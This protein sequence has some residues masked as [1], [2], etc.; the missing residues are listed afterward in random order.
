QARTQ[1]FLDVVAPQVP[2]DQLLEARAAFDED[3]APGPLHTAA[4]ALAK[5][6]ETVGG[7]DSAANAVR[8]GIGWID[9]KLKEPEQP[10]GPETKPY[11]R[12][13]MERVQGY[14]KQGMDSAAADAR[15][16]RDIEAGKDD[17]QPV[18]VETGS[19]S[20]LGTEVKRGFMGL[21][22]SLDG[23]MLSDL[24]SAVE[25]IRKKAKEQGVPPEQVT[26]V[27]GLPVD[28]NS[29]VK[30][31]QALRDKMEQRSREMSLLPQSSAVRK[32]FEGE[33]A[34]GVDNFINAFKED[35]GGAV[36]TIVGGSVP[37]SLAI[38]ATAAMTRLGGF[39]MPVTAAAGGAA[40]TSVELGNKYKENRDK[41]MGHKEAWNRA[42]IHSGAIGAF[43]AVSLASAGRALGEL[44]K[45]NAVK[46]WLKE[47]GKQAALGAGGETFG[48]ALSGEMPQPGEVAAE[49]IGEFVLGVPEGIATISR[50]GPKSDEVPPAETDPVPAEDVLGKPEQPRRP[51]KRAEGAVA[52][53]AGVG[54]LFTDPDQPVA[55]AAPGATPAAAAEAPKPPEIARGVRTR[56]ATERGAQ[57]EG[58][59][60]VVDAEAL[61]ASHDTALNVNKAYP[62]ELQPRDRTRDASEV[63][64]ARIAQNLQPEFLGGS[65]QA[66]QGAPII[67]E[68]GVVESGNARSI[69]LKRAYGEGKAESYRDWVLAN[70][71]KFGIDPAELSR[72]KRPVLV[73]VR[74]TPVNRAEFARQANESS[75]AAFSPLEQARA[76]ATRLKSLEDLQVGENGEI[77]TG[78]NMGFIRRFVGLLPVT[79]QAGLVTGTGELSQAGVTRMR[80]AVLA[81]A[82][83]GGDVLMR[84]VE[85]PDDNI[86]NITAGLVRAAPRVAK[87]R[88]EIAAGQLHDL[89]I[90]EDLLKAVEWLSRL[91]AD[92]KSVDQWM[93]QISF[94]EEDASAEFKALMRF[95]DESSRSPR[96]IAE[97]I[98]LYLAS[99]D[100]AGSPAQE[101]MFGDAVPTKSSIIEQAKKGLSREPEQQQL[102]A[103][104]AGEGTASAAAPGG[105][106][107]DR[108][109][110]GA[111]VPRPDESEAQAGPEPARAERREE[112]PA[113]PVPEPVA[114]ARTAEQAKRGI[115]PQAPKRS[116]AELERVGAEAFA[117][118]AKRMVPRDILVK[119]GVKG[120]TAWERGWDRANLAAPVPEPKKPA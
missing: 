113:A 106:Q 73:R 24:G 110:G 79:E 62:A 72:V 71:E 112:R 56:F 35:P 16:R 109:S 91:R 4:R 90:T 2:T 115:A 19:R 1:Y 18:S 67:G 45:A 83:G 105:P 80:N 41:G 63:Q 76:D 53:D 34:E 27:Q 22:N 92:R 11:D 25:F 59:F 120:G 97:F 51:R 14:M 57:L 114:P 85:S 30:S 117:A 87:A 77:Q 8:K 3:T 17:S 10:Q 15:V 60:A 99:V 70:A 52:T 119:E 102:T 64:I 68:D 66:S 6:V 36:S 13:F 94:F 108:A 38:L 48:A 54:D 61:V 103:V 50:P 69:A 111:A 55:P 104:P 39:N 65:P 43:D 82:Y 89:D 42:A 26:E 20:K 31:Y 118:G 47:S 5:T 32:M 75:V 95:L 98:E 7:I 46:V 44:T 96:R 93:A 100:A 21:R 86:R 101:S 9:E 116:D 84:M 74:T 88:E 49:A 78:A 40:S 29:A 12:P 23:M 28:Y 33:G 81:K 107:G 58:D 37:A